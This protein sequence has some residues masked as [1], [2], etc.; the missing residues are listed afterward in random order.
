MNDWKGWGAEAESLARERGLGVRKVDVDEVEV[1]QRIAAM[2]ELLPTLSGDELAH[3]HYTVGA[4]YE[5]ADWPPDRSVD[6]AVIERHAR[7]A[8]ELDGA[9]AGGWR[10]MAGVN[11]SACCH[12]R[13]EF[14]ETTSATDR[15]VL[16][17]ADTSAEDR[18]LY[19]EAV[20]RCE[21][22]LREAFRCAERAV[23]CGPNDELSEVVLDDVVGEL[24][25]LLD[26][27]EALARAPACGQTVGA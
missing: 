3:A 13:L 16:F 27:R 23:A 5:L 11:V 14:P 4:L 2:E 19:K 9:H 12:D 18:R 26:V 1:W 20:E 8:V 15:T 22:P 7:A 17:H 24:R 10:L 21:P 6:P 25:Q